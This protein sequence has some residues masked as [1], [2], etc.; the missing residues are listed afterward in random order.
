MNRVGLVYFLQNLSKIIKTG[1]NNAYYS[2]TNVNKTENI[3]MNRVDLDYF[4]HKLP[5]IIKTGPINA[6]Y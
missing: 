2:L 6:Y 3:N 4:L 1:D 5:K